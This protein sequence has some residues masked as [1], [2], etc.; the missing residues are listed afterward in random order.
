MDAIGPVPLRTARGAGR[1]DFLLDRPFDVDS[2]LRDWLPD[3]RVFEDAVVLVLPALLFDDAG[4]EDVRVA[5]LRNLHSRHSS[6]R[7]P[8]RV[9]RVQYSAVRSDRCPN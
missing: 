7:H 9:T 8:T 2:V 6:H 3:G 5:M 4:G 1:V